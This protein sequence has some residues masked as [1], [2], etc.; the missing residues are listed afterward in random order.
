MNAPTGLLD[1][2]TPS[3][4][5]RWQFWVD[6]GGTFTDI[7]AVRP[8]GQLVTHKL[9]SENP[10]QY[11]D[12]VIQ[13]IRDLLGVSPDV[14]LPHADIDVIK[15]GT[16][17]ATNALLERKGARTVLAITRGFTDQLHIGYQDRP[18][19]FARHIVLHEQ[20]FEDV[21]A[22]DER[23]DAQGNV[24]TELDEHAARATFARSASSGIRSIA[25][26]LMHGY[27]F[28]QHEVRLGELARE[29]GFT[30]ISLSHEASPLMKI[31]GRADTT[32]IDAYL[33]PVL[34]DY[35][36]RVS[37]QT[38]PTRLMFMQSSGGLSGA[39]RFQGKD[40]IL[41]GP[42]GGVVGAVKTCEIVGETRIIGFDMG[43]TSTD[44]MHYDGSYERVFETQV[45]GVRVRA[46]MMHIHTVAAGG[47]SI[48]SFHHG[49]FKV[50]PE[51]AG[52]HPGPA[53]YRN[54]G[55]VTV[56]D[57]NL[58]L[59]RIQASHFPKVFGPDANQSLS[60]SIVQQKF[61]VLGAEIEASGG[62]A[63]TPDALAEGFL[64]V[65]VDSMARAIKMISVS[66]I[67]WR[68]C[69]AVALIRAETFRRIWPT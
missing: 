40:A 14:P 65:A 37:S 22:N 69:S 8:D 10:S 54:G 23:L 11:P 45:A 56:T 42:A 9:L 20:L 62:G 49:R 31:V 63:M 68:L 6:R 60:L 34:R 28:P 13:G 7:V 25:I 27:R 35:V 48:C 32:L 59:G 3:G 2:L 19:I 58:M 47:G 1:T 50:G 12:A 41:S 38:G 61:D 18:D 4:A 64:A 24:L 51:S 46:P 53:C 33:S 29:A 16:T 67:R 66:R 15:M 44:V 52:A 5:K 43:G 39:N 55:P 57:C 21:I 36:A 17:V 30:Q 26:V